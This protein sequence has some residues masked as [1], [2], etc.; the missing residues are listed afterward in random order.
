MGGG[1]ERGGESDGDVSSA[2]SILEEG[3]KKNW[4]KYLQP[5][6]PS[7]LDARSENFLRRH[8]PT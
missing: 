3:R 7:L 5:R 1:G 8:D 6:K 2:A 4:R